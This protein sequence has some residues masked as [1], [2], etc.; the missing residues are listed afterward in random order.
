[1]T[2]RSSPTTTGSALIRAPA[3]TPRASETS[4]TVVMPGVGAS[5]GS[6]S[7]GGILTGWGSADATSTFA[8]Y[9]GARAT[10]FS[11]ASQGARNSCAPEPPI[12][13]TSA[14]TQ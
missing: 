1:M 2:M 13:P 4:S 11:P 8:A 9:P 3:G 12:I 14:S 7:G 5:R 6:S 10:S